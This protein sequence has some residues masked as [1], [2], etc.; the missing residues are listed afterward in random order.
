LKNYLQRFSH[1]AVVVDSFIY[2]VKGCLVMWRSL[3]LALAFGDNGKLVEGRDGEWRRYRERRCLTVQWRQT[4]LGG[5][6][7]SRLPWSSRLRSQGKL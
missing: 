7:C 1:S 2:M 6:A 5:W 3:P 4:L